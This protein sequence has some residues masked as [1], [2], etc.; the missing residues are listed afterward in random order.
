MPFSVWM[1]RTRQ[2]E[3]QAMHG[4]FPIEQ[5]RAR[6]ADHFLAVFGEQLDGDGVAHG[7]GGDEERGFFAGDLGGAASRWLTVGSSP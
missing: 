6:I 3:N 7:A 4:E 5:V 1:A 2:P